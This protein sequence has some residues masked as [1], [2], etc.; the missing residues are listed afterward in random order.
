M[1]ERFICPKFKIECANADPTKPNGGC[2]PESA[3]CQ[4]TAKQ[5]AIMWL[6][7]DDENIINYRGDDSWRYPENY[8]RSPD[9]FEQH[10]PY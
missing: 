10:D 1:T 7:F 9:E 3:I 4:N 2:Q 6:E 8:D 5:D